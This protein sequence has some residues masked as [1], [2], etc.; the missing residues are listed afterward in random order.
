MVSVRCSGLPC[1]PFVSLPLFRD[2]RER[3]NFKHPS[4]GGNKFQTQFP[5]DGGR[6]PYQGS[7]GPADLKVLEPQF[8]PLQNEEKNQNNEIPFRPDI[9]LL[10]TVVLA[11]GWFFINV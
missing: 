7:R 2:R 5:S 6:H 3:L 1:S 8:W 11:L 9:I 4:D 10:V